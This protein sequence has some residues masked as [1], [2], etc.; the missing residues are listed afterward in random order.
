[1][2]LRSHETLHTLLRPEDVGTT[3]YSLI[4]GL[5]HMKGSGLTMAIIGLATV[6]NETAVDMVDRTGNI[7]L[8][9]AGA[10]I[11]VGGLSL[12]AA[13]RELQREAFGFAVER[14]AEEIV[15]GF[16]SQAPSSQ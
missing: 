3:E 4:R 16:M 9:S 15:E 13:A 1:M 10:A 6:A 8:L 2:S 11:L 5:D 12:F 14:R 7:S